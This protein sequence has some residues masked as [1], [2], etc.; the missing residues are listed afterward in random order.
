[1]AFVPLYGI[2]AAAIS[3]LA[4]LLYMGFSG[5]YFKTYRKLEGLNHYPLAWLSGIVVL[6]V[7]SY[8]LKD[9]NIYIKSGITLLI[10][11]SCLSL[12]KMNYRKLKEIDV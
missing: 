2:M 9:A 7:V 11:L 4:S 3:T 6:T 12:A 8:L 10:L 5:Y 1:V